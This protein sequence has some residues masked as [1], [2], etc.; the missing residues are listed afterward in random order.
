VSRGIGPLAGWLRGPCGTPFK[1][2]QLQGFY[3]S[4]FSLYSSRK[5]QLNTYIGPPFGDSLLVFWRF[6]VYLHKTHLCLL[7]SYN[8]F[9][10]I[11]LSLKFGLILI[12]ITS[13]FVRVLINYSLFISLE[14]TYSLITKT[15]LGKASDA[16]TKLLVLVASVGIN[17]RF[18]QSEPRFSQS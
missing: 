12:L 1:G 14:N 5:H 10:D 6:T 8:F 9:K 16:Q 2:K 13:P 11:L 7:F 18:S 15:Y 4:E 3:K 17:L